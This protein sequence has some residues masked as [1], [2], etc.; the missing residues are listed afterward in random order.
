MLVTVWVISMGCNSRQSIPDY[1][2][3]GNINAN[4][5]GLLAAAALANPVWSREEVAIL[6]QLWLGSLPLRPPSPSNSFA[7]EPRAAALGHRLFFDPRLSANGQVACTTCHRPDLMFTDGLP[8]SLGTRLTKRNAQT[9]AG[10]AYSPWLLWDGH[11]DSLWAQALEPIEHPDE[12][13]STRLH[14]IHLIRRDET[15]RT[16]YEEIFGMLPPE[17]ADFNRFPDSGGPVDYAPYRTAWDSM[18][19]EDQTTTTL[20]FT[21][22]GKAIEAY[23]RLIRPGPTRFDAYAKAALAGDV[24]TM[25]NTLSPDE[26]A[27]LRLFIGRA[28][29]LGCHSG[30]LFSDHKFHNTGVPLEN[31]RLPDEGR[32]AGV[33]QLRQDE[34]NCLSPYSEATAE[35]C[36][37]LSSTGF[38]RDEL[39]YAF[40]TPSLRNLVET[41]PY[42]HTGQLATLGR[43]LEHYNR[44][45]QAPLGRSELRPLN[46]SA[47]ELALLEAFLRTLS[48]PLATP[49][50]LLEPPT[51]P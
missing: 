8:L 45:P 49:P 23:E 48:A 37:G 2:D 11:K 20:I 38:S 29:C 27:G 39:R 16:L 14:A 40:R 21:N 46:L 19:A 28:N 17:L 15:Y 9:I 35:E 31:D 5:D 24:N 25:A 51:A 13:G 47:D 34:F 42:M 33:Q 18:T 32:A 26:V 1:Y 41:A 44:A 30:P 6:R 36:A 43:V 4:R 22:L 10:A 7:D 12:Q 50:E 3:P